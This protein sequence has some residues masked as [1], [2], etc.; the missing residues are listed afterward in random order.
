MAGGNAY[1]QRAVL[2][3]QDG[4]DLQAVYYYF[5]SLGVPSPFLVAKENLI[6]LFEKVGPL[7]KSLHVTSPC[8]ADRSWGKS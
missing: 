6:Q 2:A 7:C 3:A 4:R 5:R 1:N 8:S